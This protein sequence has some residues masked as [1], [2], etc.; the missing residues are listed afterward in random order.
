MLLMAERPAG[1]SSSLLPD[2][3]EVCACA[4]VS[5]GRIRSCPDVETVAATTR[6]TT[7]CG[8]CASVVQALL[9]AERTREAAAM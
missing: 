6:A 5:A 9:G 1:E 8:G 2:D 7:G 3:A 4:G